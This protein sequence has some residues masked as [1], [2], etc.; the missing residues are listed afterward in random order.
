[1]K[2]VKMKK[3]QLYREFAKNNFETTIIDTILDSSVGETIDRGLQI[4]N[5]DIEIKKDDIVVIKPNLTTGK[6]AINSGITTPVDIIEALIRYLIGKEKD[7]RI[8]IVESDSDGGIEENFERLGYTQLLSKFSNVS[9]VDL[10]KERF[11]KIVMPQWSKVRLVSTPEILMDMNVFINVAN[12]KRHVLERLTCI[13]KNVYGLPANHLVRMRYHP[14]LNEALFALNYLFWPDLSIIDARIGLGGSGPMSGFPSDYDKLILSR[15]PLAADLAA[16]KIINED[17]KKIPAIK[18]AVRKLNLDPDKLKI[19]GDNWTPK[20]LEFISTI[21]YKILRMSMMSRRYSVYFE[22][23]FFTGWLIS[24]GLR[25]GGVKK[26]TGGGMQTLGTSLRIVLDFLTKLD[27][28]Q[29][30]HG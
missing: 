16:L 1:M 28:S 18:Y 29:Q 7:C 13:W 27:I 5:S 21:A 19:S 26:F 24:Q 17:Y 3:L 12:L 22:N 25:A 23:I 4:V 2:T 9:L 20:S 11:Y 30:V 8:C 15:N 6:S 14:F 10:G